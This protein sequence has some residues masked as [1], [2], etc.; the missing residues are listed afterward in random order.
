MKANR[1][2]NII[3]ASPGDIVVGQRIVCEVCSGINEGLL[4]NSQGISFQ[5][6]LW[7]QVFPSATH[8]RDIINRL[9]DEYDILVCILHKRFSGLSDRGELGALEEF[10]S[11]YDEWKSL[12]KPHFMFY[13]KEVN[14]SCAKDRDNPDLRNVFDLKE[15]IKRNNLLYFQE[16]S[17]PN[18]FCESIHDHLVKWASENIKKR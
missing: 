2:F 12:R 15:K 6:S 14:M 3:I 1:T 16:F 7:K 13:F 17:T 4:P 10:L 8:T 9:A 5:V 11:S 18:K